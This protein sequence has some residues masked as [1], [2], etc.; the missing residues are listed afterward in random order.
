MCPECMC[1]I[2]LLFNSHFIFFKIFQLVLWARL[3]FVFLF[4]YQTEQCRNYSQAVVG[5]LTLRHFLAT[6]S[7]GGPFGRVSL[8]VTHFTVLRG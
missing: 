8:R 4:F 3:L 5:Q 6:V 7:G 1:A 2:G